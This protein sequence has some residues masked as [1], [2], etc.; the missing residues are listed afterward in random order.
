MNVYYVGKLFKD[1]NTNLLE[2]S[3]DLSEHNDNKQMESVYTTM[4]PSYFSS[5][6]YVVLNIRS[7]TNKFIDILLTIN[8]EV[9]YEGKKRKQYQIVG[10]YSKYKIKFGYY[11]IICKRY[12]N[13]NLDN[14]DAK[15]L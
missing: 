14:C 15:K 1:R 13:D 11:N 10:Y 9:I 4:M 2:L 3:Y 12:I 5:N 6:D 7:E 8:D